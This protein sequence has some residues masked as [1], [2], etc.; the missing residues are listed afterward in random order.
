MSTKFYI[1]VHVATRHGTPEHTVQWDW[2]MKLDRL[3]PLMVRGHIEDE[4]GTYYDMDGF[5]KEIERMRI[6][7]EEESRVT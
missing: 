4:Y 1:K 3:L 6:L 5:A 7:P 2:R